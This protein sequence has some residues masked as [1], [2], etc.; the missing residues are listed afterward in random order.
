MEPRVFLTKAEVI[1]LHLLMLELKKTDLHTF[2]TNTLL[3]EFGLE[4]ICKEHK[5]I[6]SNKKKWFLTKLKHGI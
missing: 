6:V 5:Y 1:R 2:D 4:W 3:N